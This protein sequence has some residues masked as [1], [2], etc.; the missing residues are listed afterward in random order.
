GRG[1]DGVRASRGRSGR[2]RPRRGRPRS[3]AAAQALERGER[4]RIELVAHVAAGAVGV[5][6]RDEL[7]EERGGGELA[8]L[9][10]GRAANGLVGGY[11]RHLLPRPPLGREPLDERVRVLGPPHL[12]LAVAL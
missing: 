9:G 10:A 1:P 4:R 12:E 8:Y 11:D 5:L 6:R 3:L 2:S 7:G